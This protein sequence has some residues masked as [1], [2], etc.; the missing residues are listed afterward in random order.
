ME[1]NLPH[2]LTENVLMLPDKWEII[3]QKNLTAL[4]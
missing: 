2:I 3:Y 4:G 1:L